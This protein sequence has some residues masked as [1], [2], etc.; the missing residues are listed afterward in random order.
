RCIGS[1]RP[2]A[3]RRHLHRHYN[4]T[5]PL[6]ETVVNSLH[7]SCGSELTRQGISLP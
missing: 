3:G 2:A 4:F 1:F 7:D 6:S 5:E